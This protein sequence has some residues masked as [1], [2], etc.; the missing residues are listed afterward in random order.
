MCFT[1]FFR[2][3]GL[4]DITG[5]ALLHC[6]DKIIYLG[7]SSFRFQLDAT[8]RQIFHQARNFKSLRDLQS[9][10]AK[11]DALDASGEKG[12]NMMHLWHG[13][14]GSGPLVP[15][16]TNPR[17]RRAEFYLPEPI[18]CALFFTTPPGAFY[19]MTNSDS[20]GLFDNDWEDRGELSWTEKDWQK[21]LAEQE[22]AVRDYIK[23]YD[24]LAE[25]PDRIDEVARRM[26]WEMAEN[27]SAGESIEDDEIEEDDDESFDDNWDPY[28]LHRNPVYIATR[29]LYLS[30]IAHWERVAVQPGRVPPALGVTLLSS[31]YRGNEQ[32]MQAVQALEMGDY[33]LAVCLFKLA[34]CE[35]NQTLARLSQPDVA[36]TPLAMR[37]RE[38][39]LPRLFDLREIWLRVMSECRQSHGDEASPE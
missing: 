26:G 10:V 8:V 23:H 19:Y 39:A 28:T 15:S 6:G 31:L 29:S 36:A 21:Y 2:L 13:D 37:F 27:V 4:A 3:L 18:A 5:H 34:L 14:K 17:R 9:L 33:T 1:R 25:A 12:R 30:L 22:D 16:N 20:D 35:L 38:Y 32:V 7:Q 24:S 11:P